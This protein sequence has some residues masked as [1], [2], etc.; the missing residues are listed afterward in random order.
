MTKNNALGI[1]RSILGD[2]GR[3]GTRA[4][5]NFALDTLSNTDPAALFH[6]STRDKALYDIKVGAKALGHDLEDNAIHYLISTAINHIAGQQETP[7][8]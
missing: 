6:S 2:L 7:A 4:V 5:W 8:P 1:F 3:S